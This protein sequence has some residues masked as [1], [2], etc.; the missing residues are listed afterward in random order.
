MHEVHEASTHQGVVYG[1]MTSAKAAAKGT[2]T[3]LC[4]EYWGCRTLEA[5]R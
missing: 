1:S 2:F 4:K 5:R 3:V